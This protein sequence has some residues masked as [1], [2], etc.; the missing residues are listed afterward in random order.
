VVDVDIATSTVRVG[1][2]DLLDV[3]AIEGIRVVWAGPAVG[4][5]PVAVLAQVRAHG[6][7]VAAKARMEGDRLVVDLDQPIRGLAAGQAV[8]LYSGT[9]VLGSA[10]VDATHRVTVAGSP[11]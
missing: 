10:T 4:S 2:P 3:D 5:E 6:I 8:V 11:P 9:R 1:P 7:P